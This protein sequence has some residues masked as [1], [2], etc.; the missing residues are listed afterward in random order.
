MDPDIELQ[1]QAALELQSP[2]LSNV[3]HRSVKVFYNVFNHVGFGCTE[4]SFEEMK[5]I[6]F[7][8]GMDKW[9][10]VLNDDSNQNA[11]DCLIKLVCFK[12]PPS[13]DG[14]KMK[15][16]RA[17]IAHDKA[18]SL[19]HDCFLE[20]DHD[21]ID[22]AMCN[23]PTMGIYMSLSPKEKNFKKRKKATDTRSI[24]DGNNERYLHCLCAVN[25]F[26]HEQHTVVLWL[27]STRD[28]PFERS[29]HHV[30]RNKGL[31]TYLLCMLIKQHT[32][33]GDNMDQSI[34]SL[35]ASYAKN[36][37][38]CRFYQKLGF[39]HYIDPDNGLAR[40]SDEFQKLVK[41]SPHYWISDSTQPMD[42]FQL[43]GDML[44]Y[45]M[46]KS[47]VG[48]QGEEG[49]HYFLKYPWPASSMK[50]IENCVK[51]RPLFD[52]LSFMPLPETDRPLPYRMSTS[53][54]TYGWI[55]NK[56]R[57]T[58][59]SQPNYWLQTSEIQLLSAFFLRN[60]T[61]H[62]S[63]HVIVPDYTTSMRHFYNHVL[64]MGNK[65]KEEKQDTDMYK[66]FVQYFAKYLDKVRDILEHKF[67]VFLF[68]PVGSA[69]DYY[70]GGESSFGL[71]QG[72]PEEKGA[73]W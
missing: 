49:N 55:S 43:K 53:R 50:K 6:F 40:T 3:G 17:T 45:R 23:F 41:D 54:L 44:K 51:N 35:Q 37:S 70:C 61:E 48:K 30:W 42:F 63:V 46:E 5:D 9:N 2:L 72:L 13:E 64:L 34:L 73:S 12:A 24:F 10:C 7:L 27:A 68:Q 4:F 33:V 26:R 69:L 20:T 8:Q 1:L 32:G 36:E 11:S 56:W 71:Q 66:G 52:C 58:T 38:S 19:F 22:A 39:R 57:N 47:I 29:I 28:K 15:R 59:A 31:A 16:M 67:L 25:Y 14:K 60:S 18:K 65:D 21:H 62:N